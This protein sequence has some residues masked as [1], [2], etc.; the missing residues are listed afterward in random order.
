MTPWRWFLLIVL[1]C[2]LALFGSLALLMQSLVQWAGDGVHV[3]VNGEAVPIGLSVFSALQA[4][5]GLLVAVLVVLCVVP[6]A[7]VCALGAVALAA[8]GV[9]L[10]LLLVAGL[11]LSPLLLLGALLWWALRPPR[12]RPAAAA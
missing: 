5:F 12:P 4:A 11:L 10:A 1:L 3:S 7:V 2:L 8:G 6:L 9:L